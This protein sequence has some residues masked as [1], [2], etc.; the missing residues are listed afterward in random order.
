M[1]YDDDTVIILKLDARTFHT[2]FHIKYG[3]IQGYIMSA[4]L[5]NIALVSGCCC[6]LYT[7]AEEYVE[8]VQCSGG[9]RSYEIALLCYPFVVMSCSKHLTVLA[10][11][12][13]RQYC[14]IPKN[15]EVFPLNITAHQYQSRSQIV[16]LYTIYPVLNLTGNQSAIMQE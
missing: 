2:S 16:P 9:R 11:Q 12:F 3:V 13:R 15:T 5:S 7:G 8:V 6:I 1:I 4:S 10:N 14:I